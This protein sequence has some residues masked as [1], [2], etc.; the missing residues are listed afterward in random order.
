MSSHERFM[1]YLEGSYLYDQ[2]NIPEWCIQL[3]EDVVNKL[4]IQ[5]ALD[6][7]VPCVRLEGGGTFKPYYR[8][9]FPYRSINEIGTPN[10]IRVY[11]HRVINKPGNKWLITILRGP[12]YASEHAKCI[13]SAK[14]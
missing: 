5:Y 13:R 6:I 7:D 8:T 9:S 4:Y 2:Q 12:R 14:Y 10:Q 1:A 3:T 11:A